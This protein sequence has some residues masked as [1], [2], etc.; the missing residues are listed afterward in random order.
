VSSNN[1]KF[2][3][4]RVDPFMRVIYKTTE[5]NAALLL[6]LLI[7]GISLCVTLSPLVI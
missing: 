4:I 6:R 1:E 5:V 7:S 3:L 2:P